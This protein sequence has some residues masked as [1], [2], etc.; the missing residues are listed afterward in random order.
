MPTVFNHITIPSQNL[1]HSI[2]FYQALGMELI[3]YEKGHHAHFENREHEVIFTAYFNTKKPDYEVVVY[4]EVS[5]ISVLEA[6]F[7]ESIL[8]AIPSKQWNGKEL[9]LSDP[10]ENHLVLYQKFDANSIPPWQENTT[11]NQ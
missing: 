1:E 9:H 4:F 8:L 3:E 7:R 5:D 6:R 10:D 2:I 11:R